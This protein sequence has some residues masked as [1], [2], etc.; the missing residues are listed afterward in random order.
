M[1]IDFGVSKQAT[2][3]VLGKAGTMVG[4][5]GY[6]P[7]EQ[8]RGQA[9]PASDLYSLGVT[10]IRLITQC[11]PKEDGSDEL[12]DAL[13]SR[14]V[15]REHL[16]KGTVSYHL[17]QVL[18]KLIQDY[19]KERYQSADEV[20]A[21]LNSQQTLANPKSPQIPDQHNKQGSSQLPLT[22]TSSPLH[23]LT[24]VTVDYTQLKYL[25]AAGRWR[26][27]NEET[28]NV[29][30]KVSG[31]EKQGSLYLEDIE[32]FSCQDLYTIDQFWVKYSNRRFGFSVQQQIWQ[33]VGGSK[34][35]DYRIWCRFGYQVGWMRNKMLK[36]I[37][38]NDLTFSINAPTGHLPCVEMTTI[39]GMPWTCFLFSRIE[40][41]RM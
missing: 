18:D 24:T 23:N 26:D 7:L 17:G 11:L 32:K 37:W 19:V 22:V 34:N 8:M 27:A 31:R 12:Y 40:V 35:A 41:C 9:Y 20:L 1:S 5:P 13:N 29:M 39:V 21:V 38:F 15:W 30:L 4:T 10:C 28:L 33:S 14:W 6:A 3:T 2:G 16:Q 36:H 25:L